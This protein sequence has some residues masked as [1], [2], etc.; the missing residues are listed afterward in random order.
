M[1]MF[2]VANAEAL[3]MRLNTETLL[4]RTRWTLSCVLKSCAPFNPPTEYW[5]FVDHVVPVSEIASGI[6]N[7]IEILFEPSAGTPVIVESRA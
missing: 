6:W 4:A 7:V 5:M 2:I 3:R 1:L